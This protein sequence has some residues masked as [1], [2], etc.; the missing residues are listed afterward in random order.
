[1]TT[2][3]DSSTQKG[4]LD[5][6]E[7]GVLPVAGDRIAVLRWRNFNG[8]LMGCGVK[9]DGISMGLPWDSVRL[10][11]FAA[12][13]VLGTSSGGFHSHGIGWDHQVWKMTSLFFSL[14]YG[15]PWHPIDKR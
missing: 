9:F 12:I 13:F 6:S 11:R 8:S 2:S 5:Y 1:M 7:D 3:T 15:K 14:G 4:R 10:M